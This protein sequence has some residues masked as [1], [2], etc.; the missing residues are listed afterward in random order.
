MF[1]LKKRQIWELVSILP[2][3]LVFTPFLALGTL[4][5]VS[6]IPDLVSMIG[7]TAP[8]PPFHPLDTTRVTLTVHHTRVNLTLMASA[9]LLAG[10][11][12]LICSVLF[13]LSGRNKPWAACVVLIGSLS[14]ICVFICVG[15]FVWLVGCSWLPW[16]VTLLTIPVLV[17]GGRH[18]LIAVRT[19]RRVRV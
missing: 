11:I 6:M 5:L 3:A 13:E 10:I 7:T 14:F 8:S 15:F 19:L 18:F 9:L 17:V 16:F 2:A 12:V 4:A 1:Q